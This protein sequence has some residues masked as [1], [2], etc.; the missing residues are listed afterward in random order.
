MC[1][2]FAKNA[3]NI[4]FGLS[5]DGMNPFSEMSSSHS[6]WHVNL[7]TYN[8]PPWLCLKR[9]FIMMATLI[10]GQKQS[11]SDFDVYLKPLVEKLLVLWTTGVLMMSTNKKILTYMLCCSLPSTVDLHCP[12]CQDNR[13]KDSRHAPIV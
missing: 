10:Q 7:C 5:T 13:T 2:E 9:K 3:R 1:T 6:T 12:T 8:L 4:R 11:G